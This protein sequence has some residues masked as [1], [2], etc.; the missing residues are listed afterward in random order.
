MSSQSLDVAEL[1]QPPC[2]HPLHRE[3]V[4]YV[5]QFCLGFHRWCLIYTVGP[6]VDSAALQPQEH[7][8]ENQRDVSPPVI[9][10]NITDD[11]AGQEY[12]RQRLQPKPGDVFYLHL[13]DLLMSVS[14]LKSDKPWQML[15]Y[16][17]G[18]SPYRS[19]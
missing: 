16:G 19:L 6:N 9:P 13:S 11:L 2:V 10:D 14:E 1:Y 8:C 15:D 4:R 18:G 12:L 17:C 3:L 5:R 7:L